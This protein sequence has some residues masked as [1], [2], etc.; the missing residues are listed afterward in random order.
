MSNPYLHYVK[1]EYHVCI[2]FYV[3]FTTFCRM[4]RYFRL[5]TLSQNLMSYSY[6]YVQYVE[7]EFDIVLPFKY[8]S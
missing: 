1:N 4:S 6:F 7:I 8:M 3:H 5:R 2:P